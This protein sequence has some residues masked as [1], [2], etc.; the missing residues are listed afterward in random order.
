MLKIGKNKIEIETLQ[1]TL[2]ND[3]KLGDK[4][5]YQKVNNGYDLYI[6]D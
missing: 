1:T 3:L 5:N 2:S 6:S 4:M